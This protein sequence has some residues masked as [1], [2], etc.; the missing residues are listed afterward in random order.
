MIGGEGMSEYEDESLGQGRKRPRLA[1]S[2]MTM[3]TSSTS[4]DWAPLP[5]NAV[6]E[7]RVRD[8]WKP[9]DHDVCR[10]LTE[11]RKIEWRVKFCKIW[12]VKAM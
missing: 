6:W 5:Q 11:V 7:Y 8:M 2:T 10:K 12:L 9:L 3:A 1:H 4:Q